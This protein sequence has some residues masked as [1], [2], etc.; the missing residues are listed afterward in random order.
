M[1]CLFFVFQLVW[2]FD[3]V[4]AQLPPMIHRIAPVDSAVDVMEPAA[5]VSVPSVDAAHGCAFAPNK[6]KYILLI[7]LQPQGV[8]ISIEF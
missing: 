8:P 1:R 6:V 5:V 2:V 3:T 7:N 4:M